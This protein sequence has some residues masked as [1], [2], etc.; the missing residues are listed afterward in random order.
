MFIIQFH[1]SLGKQQKDELE[2]I[3]GLQFTVY[4]NI[5]VYPRTNTLECEVRW[6]PVQ[7]RVIILRLSDRHLPSFHL[8]FTDSILTLNLSSTASKSIGNRAWV[9]WRVHRE[10]DMYRPTLIISTNRLRNLL[11]TRHY[12]LCQLVSMFI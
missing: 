9:R 7:I 5:Q 6:H 3:N 12:L 10:G 2:Y 8:L 4:F 1:E 11:H